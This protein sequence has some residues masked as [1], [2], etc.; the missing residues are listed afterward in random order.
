MN[1]RFFV[2]HWMT[3]DS[4]ILDRSNNYP[5]L[6]NATGQLDELFFLFF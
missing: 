5:K 4:R 3:E 2:L 6:H 1:T